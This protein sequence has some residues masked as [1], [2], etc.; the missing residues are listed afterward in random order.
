MVLEIVKD[1]CDCKK[2]EIDKIK[3]KRDDNHST[4]ILINGEVIA[5]FS[6][7]YKKPA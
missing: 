7:V 2:E 6:E 5:R 3:L 4:A 1:G